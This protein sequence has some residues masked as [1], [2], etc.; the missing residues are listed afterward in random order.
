MRIIPIL[1][2][3]FGSCCGLARRE[4]FFLLFSL[5][6]FSP[7]IYFIRTFVSLFLLPYF[8]PI[9]FVCAPYWHHTPPSLPL[10]FIQAQ[11]LFL[12]GNNGI[13][14]PATSSSY[15]S[16]LPK[17]NVNS[18]SFLSMPYSVAQWRRVVD[19]VMLPVIF[20][21]FPVARETCVRLLH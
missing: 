15:A 21:G 16:S 14:R 4:I 7:L 12:Q 11:T 18:N 8:F 5:C 20:R 10:S 3:L 2:G 17:A 9:P 19:F 1:S 6:P 13:Y